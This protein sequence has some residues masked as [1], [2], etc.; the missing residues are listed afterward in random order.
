MGLVGKK[1]FI[2][3]LLAQSN[4]TKSLKFSPKFNLK[5]NLMF[6]VKVDKGVKLVKE[7]KVVKEVKE[8]NKILMFMVLNLA[9]IQAQEP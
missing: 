6:M 4:Q 1:L 8:V 3:R 7:A 2:N 5:F 9:A